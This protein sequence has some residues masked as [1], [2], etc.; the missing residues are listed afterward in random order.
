[1]KTAPGGM[2]EAMMADITN[3]QEKW[4]VVQIRCC[5]LSETDKGWS[6]TQHH[7]LKN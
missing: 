5:G 3:R 6:T 1:L 2:T 7:Q 4:T